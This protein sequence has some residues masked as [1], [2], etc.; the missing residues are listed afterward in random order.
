M[1]PLAWP[2][3]A[4]CFA[5]AIGFA[6]I[7]DQIKLPV[8]RPSRSSRD[9]QTLCG[10]RALGLTHINGGAPPQRISFSRTT[11]TRRVK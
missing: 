1:E 4:A 6:L 2:V 7:L 11:S 9:S 5:A 10:H 3:M 8:T